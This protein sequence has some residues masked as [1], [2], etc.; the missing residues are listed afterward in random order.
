[1]YAVLGFRKLF[2]VVAALTALIALALIATYQPA[3]H[4]EVMKVLWR[5]ATAATAIVFGLG[6]WAGFI[7]WLWRRLSW[8]I[9]PCPAGTWEGTIRSNFSRQEWLRQAARGDGDSTGRDLD[10]LL[11]EV[12]L[13]PVNCR[14]TI[15]VNLY[16]VRAVMKMPDAGPG[17]ESKT[18]TMR[19]LR[20][21]GGSTRLAYV[22]EQEQDESIGTDERSHLGS[23]LLS[24]GENGDILRGRYWTARRWEIALNT[25]GLLELKR[26]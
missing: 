24:F 4:E 11:Q 9:G 14:L 8:W 19:V 16:E 17:R 15:F 10:Q 25:A 5:S 18:L 1:M 12:E 20:D 7:N 22:Y 23:A 6:S 3:V 2:G 13:K 26:V 21:G